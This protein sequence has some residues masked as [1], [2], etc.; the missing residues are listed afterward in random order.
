MRKRLQNLPNSK[1]HHPDTAKYLRTLCGAAA[2]AL[3]GILAS[4][5]S[6]KDRHASGHDGAKPEDR[7]E[8]IPASL[9][10]AISHDLR[11]P[12]SDIM[13]NSLIYLENHET[14][15]DQEKLQLMSRIHEDSGWLIDMAENLL[16]IT[17]IG[18]VSQAIATRVEI[19]EEV[20]GEALQKIEK[21]HPG[22]TIQ[23]RIPE[24]IIMLPMD[25]PLIE[26]AIINLTEYALLNSDSGRPV[27]IDVLDGPQE[28]TFT[29]K[30]YGNDIPENL[31]DG[32]SDT[33]SRALAP[34][35]GADIGLAVC[36][37][38]ISAHHGAITGRNHGQGAEFIFTLPKRR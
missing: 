25:A 31:L 16:A 22:C 33:A 8:Q 38:I 36:K 35:K 28:V 3:T 13:G 10:R 6:A 9:L 23:V 37:I 29:V 18:D 26:Q 14:L 19:V 32:F 2:I 17:R 24:D 21:R 1:N 15:E 7:P 20:L 30:G 12:L 4:R 5:L 34:Q 11:T 27:D